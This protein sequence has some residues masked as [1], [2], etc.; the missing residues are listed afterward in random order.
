MAGDCTHERYNVEKVSLNNKLCFY[1]KQ[2]GHIQHHCP[3]KYNR[4][5]F[6][7]TTEQEGQREVRIC[8]RCNERGHVAKYCRAN[9]EE[10]NSGLSSSQPLSKEQG[11]NVSKLS[12]IAGSKNN[13]CFGRD[14]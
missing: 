14:Y 4:D 11:R 3:L 1:C 2:T 13:T 9:W 5:R 10:I 7:N 6:R 12:S 8:F